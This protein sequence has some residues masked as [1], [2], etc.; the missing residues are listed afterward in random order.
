MPAYSA[1]HPISVIAQ[2]WP[3]WLST[4]LSLGL[5][6]K[7]V[8]A[9]ERMRGLFPVMTKTKL[10]PFSWN[11]LDRLPSIDL[12]APTYILGSGSISFLEE[13]AHT[14]DSVT[15]CEG[16]WYAVDVDFRRYFR[17]RDLDRQL[18]S[19]RLRME[20]LGFQCSIV[21]HADFGG[22]TNAS[23]LLGSIGFTNCEVEASEGLPWTLGHIINPA[24][25]GS[26]LMINI[27]PPVGIVG[28]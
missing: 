15:Q 25:S 19:W 9:Q 27:P 21:Q 14:T 7:Q 22:I 13:L 8:F 24:A 2:N 6:L 26:F 16:M 1:P 17:K 12:D 28:R 4:V 10:S 5:P 23:Y 3:S 18:S 11:A 20:K